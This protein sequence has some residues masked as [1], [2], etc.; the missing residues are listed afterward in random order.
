MKRFLS[1]ILAIIPTYPVLS[2]PVRHVI[3]I[4]IDGMRPEFYEDPSWPAPNLQHLMHEGAYAVKLRPVFPT[5][6]LPN[7]T[8]MITGALPARHGVYFNAPFRPLDPAPAWNFY[9]DIIK[10]PTLF[11]KIH[12]EK[13]LTAAV[14]WPVTVGSPSID[15]NFPDYWG[16]DDKTDNI[17]LIRKGVHPAGL[18]EELEANALGKVPSE[19]IN[20]DHYLRTDENAGRIAAYLIMRYKPAFT[21]FHITE[22]DHAQHDEGRESYAIRIAVAAADR[23]IGDVLEAVERAGIQDSTTIIIAGDHGFSDIHSAIFPNVW[24]AKA[25]IF[26]PGNPHWRAKFQ[27]ASGSAF[28]YLE[29]KHDTAA[30][31]AARQTLENVPS[32]YRRLF[33]IIDRPEL[34]RLG[35]DSSAALGFAPVIGVAVG[36]SGEGEPLRAAHGGTHGFMNDTPEMYTGF[37]AYG[38]GIRKGTVIPMMS[39]PDIAPLIAKLLG[40]DFPCPDGILYPGL[41]KNK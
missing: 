38:A 14:D 11:D 8:S 16:F 36:N 5:V 39:T 17:A 3:L 26:H 24:L 4:T 20:S 22:T 2:Q 23:A 6:T 34:D 9:A 18:W 30:I 13:L 27:S 21:A 33:R 28:L 32:G 31:I 15:Y 10:S 29:D 41:L 25:G 40:I 12:E 37:I 7:H 19:E 35:V 1:L